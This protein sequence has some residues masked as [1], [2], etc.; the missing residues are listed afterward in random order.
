MEIHLHPS[1]QLSWIKK[2]WK[3]VAAENDSSSASSLFQIPPDDAS[4]FRQFASDDNSIKALLVDEPYF[5]FVDRFKPESILELAI[6]S[7]MCRPGLDMNLPE[8]LERKLKKTI[9]IS[10]VDDDLRFADIEATLDPTYGCFV[11]QEQLMALMVEVGGLS[12]S[13]ANSF[14]KALGKKMVGAI[15]P[16]SEKFIKGGLARGYQL[17]T[18]ENLLN[19]FNEPGGY[20]FNKSH[21]MNCGLVAYL[22]AFLK[23]YHPQIFESISEERADVKGA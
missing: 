9:G 3:E 20:V 17:T 18:L 5:D 12:N 7:A 11:F 19:R 6:V 10:P 23:A 1:R 2:G 14:R 21:A 15:A 8:L 4:V 22:L 16:F 13:D